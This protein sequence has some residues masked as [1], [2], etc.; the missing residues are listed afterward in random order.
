LEMLRGEDWVP[1]SVREKAQGARTD[2]YLARSDARTAR[3]RGRDCRNDGRFSR[4]P[5]RN[6]PAGR[7]DRCAIAR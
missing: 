7:A 2:L 6:H 1:R 3:H 4:R 5:A